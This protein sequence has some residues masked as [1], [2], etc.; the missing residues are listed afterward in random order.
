MNPYVRWN[1]A[2]MFSV[3]SWNEVL[4]IA[5]YDFDRYSQDGT[6]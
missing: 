1:Q 2:L 4:K 6:L 5:V 3:V